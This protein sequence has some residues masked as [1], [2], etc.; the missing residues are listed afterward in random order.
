MQLYLATILKHH[1]VRVVWRHLQASIVAG[2]TAVH[3]LCH[4]LGTL[5]IGMYGIL[6]DEGIWVQRFEEVNH[7][8]ALGLSN[9]G[10]SLLYLLVPIASA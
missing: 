4:H 9:N 2:Y 6:Q 10:N 1:I 5:G 7:L 3:Y 8:Y